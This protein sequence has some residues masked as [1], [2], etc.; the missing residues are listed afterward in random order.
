[1]LGSPSMSTS[2]FERARAK[3]GGDVAA[4]PQLW[5]DYPN[6]AVIARSRKTRGG[7]LPWLLFLLVSAALSAVV[8][9]GQQ[10]LTK[11]RARVALATREAAQLRDELATTKRQLVDAQDRASDAK[12][13]TERKA[14][15]A[16]EAH[17]LTAEQ[18][19][20]DLAPVF[21]GEAVEITP[22]DDGRVT[23]SLPARAFFGEGGKPELSMAGMR[24][25]HKLGKS[26]NT[27]ESGRS[28]RIVGEAD[29]RPARK[30]PKPWQLS[31][32]G[33]LAVTRFLAEDV[34]V[35]VPLSVAAGLEH[36]HGKAASKAGKAPAAR[37]RIEISAKAVEKA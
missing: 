28:V 35:K 14:G 13:V 21:V 33:A 2:L 18:L 4:A 29:A 37:I 31:G 5:N 20:K 25:L 36:A 1:M 15:A 34:G 9:F 24:L 3:S 19:A 17:K 12:V 27:L 16:V 30:G 11:Q 8:H 6:T 26:L 7:A 23:V 32:G 22:S 10:E